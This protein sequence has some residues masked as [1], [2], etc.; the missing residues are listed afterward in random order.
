MIAISSIIGKCAIQDWVLLRE[1]K[2]KNSHF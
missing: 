1:A 2:D